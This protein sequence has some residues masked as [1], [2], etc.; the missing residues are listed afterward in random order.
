MARNLE[1]GVYSKLNAVEKASFLELRKEPDRLKT[2]IS[3]LNQLKLE[4]PEDA[5][6]LAMIQLTEERLAQ[7]SRDFR[8]LVIRMNLKYTHPLLPGFGGSD[9]E[10]SP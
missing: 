10:I 9:V 4:D 6:T 2:A 5:E 8:K 7:S 1:T 3:K